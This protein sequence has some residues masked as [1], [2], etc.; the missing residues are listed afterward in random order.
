MD[1]DAPRDP[2]DCFDELEDPRVER[3]R[4]HRL[5]DMLA[6][7]ILAVICGAEGW[8]DMEQFGRAKYDWLKT[9]LHLPNGIPSH[10]TFGRLF[11]ALDPESFERC[12]LAWVGGLLELSVLPSMCSAGSPLSSSSPPTHARK[13]RSNDSGSS[14]ANNRPNVS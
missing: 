11:A 9:F 4:L 5:D 1:A 3:T 6:I 14:A 8:A 13:H 7:A 10:D 12:F 2:F